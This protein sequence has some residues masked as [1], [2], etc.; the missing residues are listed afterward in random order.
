MFTIVCGNTFRSRTRSSSGPLQRDEAGHLQRCEQTIARRGIVQK[1]YVARLFAAQIGSAAQHLFQ[2][3][4]IAD[5][6]ARQRK[7]VRSSARSRPRFV[8]SGANHPS[9]FQLAG[10]RADGKPWPATHH[11]R[12]STRPLALTSMA[13]SASPSNA[14]PSAARSATTRFCKC[15]GCSEPLVGIDVAT[16]GLIVDRHHVRAERTKQRRAQPN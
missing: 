6:H 9:A 14:T 15:S 7:S 10:V 2:H 16:V 4:A 8:I 5:G 12:R 11:R 3:V 13:R 1:N